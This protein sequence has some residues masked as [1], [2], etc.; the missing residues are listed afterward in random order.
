MSKFFRALLIT[1]ATTGAVALLLNALDLESVEV[2]SASEP[3]FPGMNPDDLSEEDVDALMQE[4]ANQLK[5]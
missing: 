1:A 3:D 2:P 4:L 5:I